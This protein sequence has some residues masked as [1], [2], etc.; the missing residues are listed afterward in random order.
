MALSLQIWVQTQSLLFIS[1]VSLGLS[2]S[3]SLPVK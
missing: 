1:F 3:V 2:E